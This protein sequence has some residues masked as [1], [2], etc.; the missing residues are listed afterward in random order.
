MAIELMFRA[1]RFKALPLETVEDFWGVAFDNPRSGMTVEQAEILTGAAYS[2]CLPGAA[3]RTAR[4][5]YVGVW[6]MPSQN[7][8]EEYIAVFNEDGDLTELYTLNDFTALLA[9][10]FEED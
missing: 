5:E 2:E 4:Y 8:V 9:E 6:T 1:G 3:F 7:D 10:Y